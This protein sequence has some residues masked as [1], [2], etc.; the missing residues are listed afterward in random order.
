MCCFPGPVSTLGSLPGVFQT[1]FRGRFRVRAITVQALTF[2]KARACHNGLAGVK[3][4]NCPSKFFS[5]TVSRHVGDPPDVVNGTRGIMRDVL[6]GHR[7]KDTQIG[8]IPPTGVFPEKGPKPAHSGAVPA[9]TAGRR[10]AWDATSGP[11]PGLFADPNPSRQ[12]F[13]KPGKAAR[14]HPEAGGEGPKRAR[15]NQKPGLKP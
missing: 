5:G 1:V 7:P 15:G 2:S 8:T 10:W 13:A 14:S 4:F 12:G 9:G 11:V 3:C 6:R